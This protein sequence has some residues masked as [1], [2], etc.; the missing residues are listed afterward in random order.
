MGGNTRLPLSASIKQCAMQQPLAQRGYQ[1]D[2]HPTRKSVSEPKDTSHP[3]RYSIP[4][5]FSGRPIQVEPIVIQSTLSKI[6]FSRYTISV[7]F[8]EIRW[9]PHYISFVYSI[10]NILYIV[11]TRLNLIKYAQYFIKIYI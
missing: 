1:Q 7:R 3:P 11:Y 5:N 6:Y 4:V 2:H 8:T 10:W 9:R